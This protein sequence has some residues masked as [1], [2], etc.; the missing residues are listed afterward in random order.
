MR[1]GVAATPLPHRLAALGRHLRVRLADPSPAVLACAAFLVAATGFLFGERT[2]VNLGLGWDGVYYARWARDFEQEIF[3]KRVDTYYVQRILPSAVVYGTL[4]LLHVPTS[5]ENVIRAFALFSVGLLTL[6]GYVWGRV[7][8]ELRVS[9]AGRWLGFAG[10]FLNFLTLKQA[11]YFSVST[12]VWAYTLGLLMLLAYLT[13][14]PL[15][16]AALTAAGA[17][18][19]PLSVPVGAMLL[20]FPRRESA[21]MDGGPPYRLHLVAAG[22]GTVIALAGICY[23]VQAGPS[24]AGGLVRSVYLEPIRPVLTLSYAAAGGYLFAGAAGLLRSGRLT[25]WREYVGRRQLGGAILAAG[26]WLAAR[27]LQAAWSNGEYFFGVREMLAI[28]ALSA[29]A[30]PGVFA[31]THAAFYGPLVLLAAF[32][33]QPVCRLLHR[34]GVGLTLAVLL[35]FLLSLNSQSRYVLNVWVMLVPFVV[36]AADDLGWMPGQYGL[37]AGLCLLFS[38]CWLTINVAPFTY[39]LHEFP[40]QLLFMTYGPW[41]SDTMYAVQGVVVLA[42]GY[43]L[44][45]TCIRTPAADARTS[46]APAR[47]A[48]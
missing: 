7:A 5:H 33:W 47:R 43:V 21:A 1:S 25:D 41:I 37:I 32:L 23:A 8:A 10:L 2:E 39:R 31:V 44:Y 12:D 16:L 15:A 35:A 14:R 42:A 45:T 9:P 46:Q 6:A 4:R 48:A 34:Q 30:K 40:D 19:W 38:K 26:V 36:K 11:F 18:T 24:L 27:T 13:G 29:A 17:F 3:V 20:V 28:T 22:V